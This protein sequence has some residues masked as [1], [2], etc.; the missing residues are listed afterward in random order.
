[1]PS[2]GSF[3]MPVFQL[4]QPFVLNIR[5]RPWLLDRPVVMGILNLTDDSFY[6]G[7]RVGAAAAADRATTML[8]EGAA[9]LDL[10]A[11]STRPGAA[12]V[13][14]QQ[15]LDRL[16]P[17]IESIL[18]RHPDAII[19]VDT[20]RGRVAREAVAAGAAI[21]NDVSAGALDETMLET[22]AAVNVPYVLMHMRGTPAT[23]NQLTDYQ[24]IAAQ[25]PA[26]LFEKFS[27]LRQ[28][29]VKDIIIDPGFG[30]AKQAVH[31]FQ[32]LQQLQHLQQVFQVPMLA[33]LS[34]KRSV[35]QT[36]G[37]TANEALNGTTVA[38]TLALVQGAHVLRVHDVTA[39][40]QA[41]KLYEAVCETN[42][43]RNW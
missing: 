12:P 16:L 40:A 30:F 21:I 34:R 9:I 23:M 25:V 43:A 31:N 1:M 3:F 37:V 15:E 24:N 26:E 13:P 36:L 19:S 29:G 5:N 4:P 22:V 7:S 28:A 2:A 6:A 27:W 11:C 33:G 38:N 35:W 32:L 8:A 41:I 20:F 18:A 10:G 42:S 17:A 39:A 14:E